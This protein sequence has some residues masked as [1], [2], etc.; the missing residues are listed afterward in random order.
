MSLALLA[1]TVLAVLGWLLAGLSWSLCSDRRA[2]FARRPVVLA[3][4][5]WSRSF[6]PPVGVLRW[7]PRFAV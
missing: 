2:L 1:R 4:L 7:S 5:G 3:V 6:C